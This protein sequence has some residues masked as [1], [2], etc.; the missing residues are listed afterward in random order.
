M[1]KVSLNFTKKE[2]TLQDTVKL[3]LKVKNNTKCVSSD[4]NFSIKGYI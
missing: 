3:G 2:D 4:R 1:L